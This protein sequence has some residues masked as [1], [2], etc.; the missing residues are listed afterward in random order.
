MANAV[1]TWNLDGALPINDMTGQTVTFVYPYSTT[2]KSYLVTLYKD[3]VACSPAQT[4]MILAGPAQPTIGVVGGGNLNGKIISACGAAQSVTVIINN[5][6]PSPGNNTGYTINWGDNTAVQSFTNTTFDINIPVMHDYTGLGYKTITLTATSANGCTATNTYQFFNGSNPSIGMANPGGTTG[7]CAPAT[8]SF[9]LTNYQNNPPGTTYTF[10]L[11]GLV[12]GNFDQNTIQ[13]NF[14]YSF[15]QSSCGK[16][17]LTPGYQNAFELT[18]D[19]VNPC[20]KSSATVVPITLSTAP[21]PA[22]G[23]Q[24]PINQCPNEVFVFTNASTNIHEINTQTQLCN[25]T[26]SANWMITPGTINVDWAIVSGGLFN[27]NKIK[28]KFLKPGTYTVKMTINPQPFCGPAVTSTTVTILEPPT[29]IANTQSSNP[30]GCAPLTVDFNNQSTGYQVNYQWTI[31][32]AT[33]WAWAPGSSTTTMSPTAIFSTPGIYTVTL[34]AINVCSTSTWTTQ[35]VV[36]SKPT[37]TLPMLGPFCQSA[38]LNFTLQNTAYG[39]GNGIITDYSWSF[40]G[41]TPATSTLQFPTNIQFGPVGTATTF[42]YTASAT[43]ECGTTT[44]TKSF[45]IQ[46]PSVL[47]V[48]ADTTLCNDASPLQLVGLP[49]GGM[50]S[51]PGVNAA[52]LFTP[53]NAGGP[54]VKTLTYTYGVTGACTATKVVKITV[55]A[56]PIVNAGLDLSACKDALPVTLAGSP[57]GAGGVW[58]TTSPGLSGNTFD[59]ALAPVGPHTLTYTFTNAIGCKKSD[60]LI[61]TVNPLPVINVNDTTYCNTPGL[62]NPPVATPP[63][64]TWSLFPLNPTMVGNFPATY[65]YTNPITGCKNSKTINVS[66]IAPPM[67]EAGAN[68][69]LCASITAFNLMTPDVSPAGGTWTSSSGTGIS[70]N[71]FNPSL[72]GAGAYTLTYCFGAGNC[73]VCDTRTVVVNPLPVVSAGSDIKACLDETAITLM[74]TPAAANGWTSN[75]PATISGNIFNPMASGVNNYTLTYTF[76]DA[77]GCVKSDNMVLTVQ[78]LPVIL[79][80]D[81]TYCNT[82]GPVNPPNALPVGGTWSGFSF[83]P[84]AVGLFP[85]TYTYTNPVTGC[86]ASKTINVSVI[87]PQTLEA[88]ANAALC[89][90]ATSFDLSAGAVPAGGTWTSSSGTGVSGNNFNP[91]LVGTGTYILTY[92]VGAGNCKVCDTRSIVVNPLPTVNAGPDAKACFMETAVPLTGIPAGGSWAASSPGSVTGNVFNP[93]ASGVNTY[94]LT[95]TVVDQSGCQNSDALIFKVNPLPSVASHDTTFCNTPGQVLLPAATPANGS[96]TG[97][98]VNGFN[99]NPA[100]AG[101][102][103]NYPVTYHYTDGAGCTDSTTVTVA[104]VEPT[105]PYAGVDDTVCIYTGA[106]QLTGFTPTMGGTWSG[107]GIANPQTGLFAPQTG[108]FYPLVYKYGAGNCALYDTLQ[109]LVIAAAVAAGT[110]RSACLNDLPFTLTGF[111]PT[112]GAWSGTGITGTNGAFSPGQAGVGV[113]TLRYVLIDPIIGCSFQDSLLLQVNPLPGSAFLQPTSSCINEAVQ[114]ENLSTS[115]FEV[116]WAFGDGGFSNL[117]NPVHIYTDTGTYTVKLLTTTEFGCQDSML[118]SIFVTEPPTALFTAMPDSGCATLNVSLLNQS[119]GYG[120]TYAWSFGSTLYDPGMLLLA[121]GTQDTTYYITLTTTNLCAAR[122]WTDSIVVHPLPMVLFGINQDTICSGVIIHFENHSTGNPGSFFWDFGNG[123]TSMDSLPA[124]RQFFTDSL[125]RTYTIRLISTNFCG[126]D[127]AYH[128][129]VVKPAAVTSFFNLPNATGC[130]PYTVQLINYGTPGAGVNWEFGDGQVSAELD[131]LHTFQSAGVFKVV[132]RISAGC[133]YDSSYQYVTVLPAPQVSFATLPQVCRREALHFTNTSADLAGTTWWFGDGDSSLVYHPDHVFLTAGNYTVTLTGISAANGCPASFSQIVKVL[134]LPVIHFIPDQ[135]DGCIPLTIAFSNQSQNA[136]Y[137]DWDFGDNNTL[138]GTDVSHTYTDAGQYAVQLRGIDLNGCRNDS[139]WYYVIAHP[140]PSP[141]FSL[142]RNHI[143]GI[144]VTVNVA[145]QTPDAVDYLWT[146]GDGSTPTVTNNPIHTYTQA[147]DFQVVL[148]AMNSFGC[149]DTANQV[150]PAYIEPVADFTFDPAIGCAPLQVSFESFSSGVTSAHWQFSDGEGSDSLEQVAHTFWQAGQYGAL[151][152]VSHRDVCFDSLA[153][154][155]VITVLPSP[156]ANFAFAENL[157]AP[158]SGSFTFTDLSVNAM[159]W[160]WDF[161]D[162]GHSDQQHPEHRYYSNGLKT[163]TLTVTS[164]NACT[165][166][167]TLQVVPTMMRG[168]F[169]PNAFTPSLANGQASVFQP[170]GIGLTEFE[171]E[172]YS[173]YGQLLWQSTLLNAGQPAEHWDGS[174]KGVLQPQDVYTWQVRKAVF[175]DGTS[176]EGKRV[177]SVTLIR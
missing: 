3:G 78:P 140:V 118:R 85:A 19:A 107:T 80:N 81:T 163:V 75:P 42:T 168:L 22:I 18:V 33:G 24:A 103:G 106:L 165:D 164:A 125:Y 123:T 46:V 77:N 173:S 57:A 157:P 116:K 121:G 147:G 119:Y 71:I 108:G 28:V 25:D 102:A 87:D 43:N 160:E 170:A 146:F 145:N 111:S 38:T 120:S 74:G 51:G 104:V 115:T 31:I 134:E 21:N 49:A 29:A 59:P 148:T 150:F 47:T 130:A 133:G 4:I 137:F 126:A 88:G 10:Y 89:T 127:T 63:G 36:K 40:M 143:C 131:P 95:Y 48:P 14:T 99:F 162:G 54:G 177:G 72:V 129:L 83:T 55:A 6:S 158:P 117:P 151:L 159:Q 100:G 110:D 69:A 53:A 8:I 23:V 34:K 73:K 97:A 93:M 66:V 161:G 45:D 11:N 139:T 153:L 16:T 155:N 96:W 109:V 9:P 90:N 70:G 175:E 17:P 94:T 39:S 149:Q 174:Y 5:T 132:Q 141:A 50:W 98:G 44:A 135:P 12:V 30:N 58:T 20:G 32:P 138:T 172:I 128:D 65:T 35:I 7:L 167:T 67:A 86:T 156:T 142:Q 114:F 76:T 166:D 144:P 124:A 37:I 82:P 27:F 26:L 15:T 91:S 41:G 79:V 136:A 176:W 84:T 68:T 101:G 2:A 113:H 92:C 169:L 62:V 152:V 122:T 64:G 1:Y 60:A 105:L 112:G 56:L 154:T 171:I 52:G 61:L 13:N